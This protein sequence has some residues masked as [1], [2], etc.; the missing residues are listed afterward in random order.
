MAIA[1]Q[2]TTLVAVRI[3]ERYLE[4]RPRACAT[5]PASIASTAV[6]A[7]ARFAT[8][9]RTRQPVHPA[10]AGRAFAA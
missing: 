3:P 10:V 6:R 1:P 7:V 5:R 2:Y 4:R 8:R 9:A